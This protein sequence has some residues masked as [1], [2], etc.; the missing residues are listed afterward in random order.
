MSE[1]DF[2]NTVPGIDVSQ[3]QGKIDWKAVKQSGKIFVYIKATDGINGVDPMFEE[4]WNDSKSAGIIRGAYHF[5]YAN[6]DAEAQATNFIKNVTGFSKG[7][8]PPVLD[9]EI[10][11]NA[12]PQLIIQNSLRMLELLRE[13][14]NVTPVVYTNPT[15][16]NRYL[17]ARFERFPL[18]IANYSVNRPVIPSAWQKRGFTFWQYSESGKVNGIF[19]NADLDLFNGTFEDFQKFLFTSSV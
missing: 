1:I 15:F 7:D 4:N 8:L 10:T 12:E 13:K 2:L 9:L 16:G 11:N 17:D 18:W 6:E 5:F 3:Y 14:Y 19:G